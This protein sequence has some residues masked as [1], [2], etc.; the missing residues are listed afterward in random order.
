MFWKK[1]IEFIEG[2]KRNLLRK[3][4]VA[5]FDAGLF[6]NNDV[7]KRVLNYNS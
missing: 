2:L 7:I 4:I 6:C 5:S 3:K 1:K